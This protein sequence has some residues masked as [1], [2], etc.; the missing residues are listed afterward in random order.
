MEH[1]AAL[2]RR[3]DITAVRRRD[4]PG[5]RGHARRLQGSRL[6]GD[7][8]PL[9]RHRSG[10][11]RPHARAQRAQRAR[12]SRAGRHVRQP[13]ALAAPAFGRRRRC[14]LPARG[15]WAAPSSP[16]CCGRDSAARSIRSSPHA[17]VRD[18]DR[19]RGWRHMRG[20]PTFRGRSIC[21]SWPSPPRRP[22][23]SS[24][25][26]GA[27]VKAMVVLSPGFADIGPEGAELEAQ[28]L[29]RARH[30][31]VRL[32]GPNC[33]GV[34]STAPGSVPGR[35]LRAAP[36]PAGAGRRAH[37]I[38]WA[39]D[40]AARTHPPGGNRAVEL[41][42][43]RQQGRRQR[44]RPAVVVGRRSGDRH[45]RA[46]PGIV[47]QSAQVRPRSPATSPAQAGGRDQSRQ[48]GSGLA[49]RP[50][51]HRVS[52]RRAGAFGAR[53]LSARPGSSTSIMSASSSMS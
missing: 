50:L 9:A 33:L 19:S 48:D 25:I 30:A 12:S 41:R 39:R 37:A 44:Q 7:V 47:R 5:Q 43:G 42:L 17:R 27:Q 18:R 6:C 35:D 46:V 34:T 16:T 3:R 32:V 22:S 8:S 51:A 49:R 21:S 14:Q 20:W 29:A 52:G 53:A 40:R 31:G 28:L 45:R 38:G 1:L 36:S 10:L 15:P 11:D 13:H 23:P 4:A 26:A 24:M 2:A